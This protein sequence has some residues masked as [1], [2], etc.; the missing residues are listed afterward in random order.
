MSKKYEEMDNERFMA[1][2][3]GIVDN[4]Q[5]DSDGLKKVIVGWG[6]K[7]QYC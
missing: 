5:A 3:K 1:Y 2:I 7:N 4:T 6:M